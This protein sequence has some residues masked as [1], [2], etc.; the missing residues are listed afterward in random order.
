M[1][2]RL[3][4][5]AYDEGAAQ[6][7]SILN[8][9]HDIALLCEGDPL[10]YGSFMY[11]AHRLADEFQINVVSGV[12][13]LT[14]CAGVMN[15]PLGARDQCLSVL[16]ATLSDQQLVD[17]IERSDTVAIMKIGRHLPKIKA[18][19]TRLDLLDRAQFI[20]HASLPNQMGRATWRFYRRCA[21]FFDDPT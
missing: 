9:G 4:Q 12:S 15:F 5:R 19:L 18:L 13:A 1:N 11:L 10:F 16:P 21:I 2:A 3:P 8:D 14:A 6:M 20:A 7:R 17:H